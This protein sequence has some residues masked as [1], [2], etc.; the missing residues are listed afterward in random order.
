M[1]RRSS[2]LAP[3]SAFICIL[4]AVHFLAGCQ[5]E[6][7]QEKVKKVILTIQKAVEAKSIRGVLDCMSKAYHDQQGY[8]YEGIKGLLL[9]SF[10]QHQKVSV[11][12]SSPDVVV[13]GVSATVSFQAVLSGGNNVESVRDILPESLGMYVFEVSMA[14]ET[15][16]WKV[17]SARWER[18]G[19]GQPERAH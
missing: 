7:E 13:A 2:F 18:F 6:T 11:H 14:R 3:W 4:I 12:I 10:Y 8:D 17:A 9:L 19:E 1:Y 15:G 16:E 5:K